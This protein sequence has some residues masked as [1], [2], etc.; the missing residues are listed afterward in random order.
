MV[1]LGPLRVRALVLL[2]WPRTGLAVANAAVAADL[3]QPLDIQGNLTAQ[4]AFHHVALVD[5][6]TKLG[7][8][9]LGQILDAGVGVDPSLRQ[10]VLGA[11][12][13]NTVDIGQTDFDSLI[14]GQVNTGNTC[15]TLKHLHFLLSPDAACAWDSRRSP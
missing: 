11:L 12:S 6:F 3:G 10:D 13:A 9:G 4:V 14:L 7:F 8:V 5:G 15:H 1:F 2:R